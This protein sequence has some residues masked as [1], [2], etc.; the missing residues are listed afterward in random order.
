MLTN[1]QHST[2]LAALR[3]YQANGLDAL[4][5]GISAI[6]SNDGAHEPLGADAIDDLCELINGGAG[7][8]RL[9]VQVEG[10]SVR[11]VLAE[12][13]LVT[14]VQVFVMDY[15]AENADESEITRVTQE[16]GRV[17]DAVVS[18]H[19][20]T[21]DVGIKMSDVFGETLAPAR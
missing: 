6:A 21:T 17:C 1:A 4:D 12:R 11:A 10:G 20:P 8:T 7:P 3:F 9:I 14:D 2:L 18:M 19:E 5:Q 15:D 16:N 13:E